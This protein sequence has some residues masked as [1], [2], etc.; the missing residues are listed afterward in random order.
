M[1]GTYDTQNKWNS[2]QDDWICVHHSVS[3]Q[4]TTRKEI[5]TNNLVD[6]I[7]LTKGYTK[8]CC[9]TPL[10][11]RYVGDRRKRTSDQTQTRDLC[12]ILEF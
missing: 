3:A 8:G 7:N 6:Y 1:S 5:A 10:L 2:P 9:G 4:G 12:S 11:R